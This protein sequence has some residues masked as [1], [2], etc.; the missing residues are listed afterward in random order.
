MAQYSLSPKNES[1]NLLFRKLFPQP[2]FSA[3]NSQLVNE[4][5]MKSFAKDTSFKTLYHPVKH[6]IVTDTYIIP[7]SDGG[8]ITGYMTKRL[9]KKS[10][11][12][13]ALIIY[14]HDGGWTY[15]NMDIVNA[16]CSNIVNVTG[17]QVLAIDYRLAPKFKFP[18]PLEDCFDA[19][20][21]AIQGTR[22]WRLD[23]TRVYIMGC[24]CGANI[25]SALSVLIR[26]RKIQKPAGQILIDP[27]TDCRL[28]TSSIANNSKTSL[29]TV[30]ELSMFIGNYQRE[31]KD[32]LDPLFSPLLAMDFSRLP[33]T[34]VLTADNDILFDD[35]SLYVQALK[36]ADTPTKLITCN[37]RPHGF[38]NYPKFAGWK[39]TMN[40]IELFLE[41]NVGIDSIEIM[42]RFELFK[43]RKRRGPVVLKS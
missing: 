36:S 26:D 14:V 16:I 39:D 6:N 42:T 28:R 3:M 9:R 31:P 20:T 17:A 27:V 15:G 40:A 11:D 34:L 25:A 38:M 41:D 24:G 22:Y 18:I 33:Q 37:G 23:P 1:L 12:S 4:F 5:N 19:Y 29:V 7:T 32:I 30:K 8:A 21:W 35:A 13:P 43:F 2:D 10:S